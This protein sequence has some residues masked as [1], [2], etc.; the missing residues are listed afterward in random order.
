MPRRILVADDNQMVRQT[1]A[2]MLRKGGFDVCGEAVDGQDAV[3]KA[4]TLQPNLIL[5]DL[6]MPT[7]NGLEASRVISEALSAVPIVL[8]TLYVSN[9]LEVE[10]TKNGISW[11][12]PKSEGYKLV[13]QVRGFFAEPTL[14]LGGGTIGA[15]SRPIP[16]RGL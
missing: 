4:L 8:H 3:A 16:V 2:A 5:M 10:A 15:D 12:L 7:M 14:S 1:I 6:V 9:I 11:V 13:S